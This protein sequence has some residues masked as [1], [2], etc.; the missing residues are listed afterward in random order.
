MR[1]PQTRRRQA[2]FVAR[3]PNFIQR[4]HSAGAQRPLF[5]IAAAHRRCSEGR[6]TANGGHS[7][8]LC[9][10]SV[11]ALLSLVHKVHQCIFSWSDQ[12]NNDTAEAEENAV[13]PTAVGFAGV[14]PT[15]FKM[16]GTGTEGYCP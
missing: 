3:D 14:I 7:L 4:S 13:L 2:A 9:L 11:I 1:R 5:P 8:V 15:V 6:I 12:I 16:Y 10:A